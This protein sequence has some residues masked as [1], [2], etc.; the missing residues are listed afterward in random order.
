MIQPRT[1]VDMPNSDPPFATVIETYY[2][3]DL[4]YNMEILR[5]RN[6]W[7]GGGGSV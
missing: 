6:V 3:T 4:C 5:G 1:S 2:N 7:E